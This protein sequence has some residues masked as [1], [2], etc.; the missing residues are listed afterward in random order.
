[1]KSAGHESHAITLP[2]LAER[3]GELSH[4]LGVMA[5]VRDVIAAC[6]RLDIRDGIMV[7]HSYA[8]AVVGA[9]ARRIPERLSAQVYL[10]TLPLAEGGAWADGM[11]PERRANFE[12]SLRIQ[13]GTR[14]WPMPEPLGSQAPVDGLTQED[15]DLLR[16]RG[17]P[18]PALTFEEKLSGKVSDLPA[19]RS[20]AISC[21]ED[22]AAAAAEKAQF[23]SQFPGWTYSWLPICHWPMLSSPRELAEALDGIAAGKSA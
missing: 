7:G 13:N 20:H 15:L 1:M 21:V 5:H 12:R 11:P 2:G 14:V 16:R 3:S 9:V 18:H 10:D 17:T 6:E 4:S 22:E 8:G 19:P 23:L